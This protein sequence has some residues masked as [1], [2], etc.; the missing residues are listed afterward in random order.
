MGPAH[1]EA[2]AADKEG[3]QS[4]L[5]TRSSQRCQGDLEAAISAEVVS[6]LQ[7]FRP[8]RSKP[9]GRHYGLPRPSLHHW[10]IVILTRAYSHAA[11]VVTLGYKGTCSAFADVRDKPRNIRSAT[12]RSRS[13]RA[14]V[15]PDCLKLFPW[16]GRHAPSWTD[17][18]P[19]LLFF[20]FFC[21]EWYAE[22]GKQ[23][24]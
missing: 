24:G 7:I 1:R 14:K 12:S 13:S 21:G 5:P 10:S 17:W 23:A 6:V 2:V 9:H 22:A 19:L 3:L 18:V 11:P 20:F 15:P 4:L 8:A 16:D